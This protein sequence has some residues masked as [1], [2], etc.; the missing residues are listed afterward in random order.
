[1][2]CRPLKKKL[3]TL[4][5]KRINPRMLLKTM[6]RSIETVSKAAMSLKIQVLRLKMREYY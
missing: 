2:S 5:N 4:K 1:M 6:E 3:V